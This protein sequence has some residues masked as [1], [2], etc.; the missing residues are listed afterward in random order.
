MTMTHRDFFRRTAVCARTK[1]WCGLLLA[2][3][4]AAAPLAP[5]AAADEIFLRIDGV[6]GEST[7]ARHRGEIEILSYTQSL[8]RPAF[9]GTASVTGDA[10]LCVPV[11]LLKYVDAASPRL[12]KFLATGEHFKT[13]AITFRRPGQPP[14]EYYRVTLDDVI[15]T[16]LEQSNTRLNFPNPAPPRALE[17]VTLSA[18]RVRFEYLTQQPDG[19][20]ASKM[21]WDCVTNRPI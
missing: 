10:K 19:K 2:G 16:E 1:R 13:A 21:G 15:V 3:A 20:L 5:A 7:D 14:V 8:T 11:T 9:R 17:K 12:I 6:Q 18:G 4:L